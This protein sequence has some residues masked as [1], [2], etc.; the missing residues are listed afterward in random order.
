MMM[1]LLGKALFLILMKRRRFVLFTS[2]FYYF[3]FYIQG[4]SDENLTSDKIK[5]L[6]FFNE[7]GEQEMT[8]IQ[9]GC[10]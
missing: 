6:K 9:V 7:G 3:F 10:R 1:N 5:V 4:P 8:G 2:L